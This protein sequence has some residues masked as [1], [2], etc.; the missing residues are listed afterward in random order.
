MRCP[1]C[2]RETAT[3]KTVLRNNTVTTGCERCLNNHIQGKSHN[4]KYLREDQKR[5]Y[6]KEL[7]QPNDQ[8]NFIKA[9][10]ERAEEYYSESDMRKY[11]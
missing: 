8:R 2:Q 11:G 6:R 9:Y 7:T 3:I 5:T 10:P 4:A 1:N